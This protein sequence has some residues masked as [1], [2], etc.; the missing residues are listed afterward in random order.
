ME[1]RD[2]TGSA[3]TRSIPVSF[4]IYHVINCC[5]YFY[6]ECW[7]SCFIGCMRKD[8]NKIFTYCNLGILSWLVASTRTWQ[9]FSWFSLGKRHRYTVWE[10]L[11]A[12]VDRRKMDIIMVG[13]LTVLLS[14]LRNY[15][16]TAWYNITTSITLVM[17]RY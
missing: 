16:D 3:S 13:L 15:A 9:C 6:F 2:F 17:S 11:Y 4:R 8:S 7:M 10:A 12:V 5:I 14:K 1:W